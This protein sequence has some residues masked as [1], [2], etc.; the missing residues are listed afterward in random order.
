MTSSFN[1]FKVPFENI[2]A[3]RCADVLKYLCPSL[4]PPVILQG[5]G[6]RIAAWLQPPSIATGFLGKVSDEKRHQNGWIRWEIHDTPCP[7]VVF[8]YKRQVS[9]DARAI[10]QETYPTILIDRHRDLVHLT[11]NSVVEAYYFWYLVENIIEHRKLV[12]AKT[13]SSCLAILAKERHLL[14]Q[15]CRQS[16]SPNRKNFLKYL[17]LTTFFVTAFAHK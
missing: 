7:N 3:I 10:I 11:V 12:L 15:L 14:E 4:E 16:K 8:T 1:M 6:Q 5:E 13:G 2:D 9:D 17:P